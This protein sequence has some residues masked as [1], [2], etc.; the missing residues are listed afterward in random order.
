MKTEDYLTDAPGSDA[1]ADFIGEGIGD[2]YLVL[3]VTT[4]WNQSW[5]KYL[6][7][8]F[9]GVFYKI[10]ADR[11]IPSHFDWPEFCLNGSGIVSVEYEGVKIAIFRRYSEYGATHTWVF[12]EQG[13][14]EK[15]KKLLGVL[16]S[17]EREARELHVWCVKD[18]ALDK[19]DV[20]NF[21]C[22]A[23]VEEIFE[24]EV[25]PQMKEEI[26]N[27]ILLYSFPGVGKTAFCR[28]LAKNHPDWQT[29]VVVPSAIEKP[30]NILSAFDYAIYREPAILIF[31]DVDTWAQ[32]R[33]EGESLKETFSPFLGALLNAIDGM[34]T[35]QK[36]LV[37]ATTN[38]P[39]CL[40]PA[41]IR[42]GRLGIQVEFRYTQ[43]ELVRLC[44]NYLGAS[45][46]NAFYKQ[47]IRN[48][49]AHLRAVM[50]TSR[51]YAK[52]N[53]LEVD[54]PLLREINTLLE[55]SPKLPSLDDMFIEKAE[56]SEAETPAYR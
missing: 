33:Y 16:L 7:S 2:D 22:P 34:E 28:W 4:V 3:D 32:S 39:A 31:E 44:N 25:Y 27:H 52:L 8:E 46:K 47:I 36:L 18:V 29:I 10:V 43:D 54:R 6:K 56:K 55:A 48:T 37:I 42:A 38:N 9:D 51:A 5:L 50:K 14:H 15:V 13:R 26:F 53:H 24:K 11:T 20:S 1:L 23:Y 30:H 35:R 45:H 49:P 21:V 17:L 12:C 19:L 40:D 41:I